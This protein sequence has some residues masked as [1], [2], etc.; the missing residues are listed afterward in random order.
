MELLP[1]EIRVLG[2]LLEKQHTTPDAYPLTLN[3]LRLAC[4]QST[5]RDPVVD[6]SEQ[7]VRDALQRLERQGLV[8]FASGAGSRAAKFRHLLVERISMDEAEQAVMCVLMLRGGQT[9]G[10]LKQRGERIHR[11]ADLA[12]VGTVLQRLM[13]RGLAARLPRQPGQKE[14]R[15]IHLLAA[16]QVAS[17]DMG[18]AQ[19]AT[20]GAAAGQPAGIGAAAGRPAVT[21]TSSDSEDD[22]EGWHG[23]ATAGLPGAAEESPGA[24]VGA[25][26]TVRA[27]A[28]PGAASAGAAP[29]QALSEQ[30]LELRRLSERV[31]RLERELASL[32]EDLG[33]ETEG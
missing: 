7:Q 6:Y 32:K 4:N 17:M 30:A 5:N 16:E 2:C 21:D 12:E 25:E 31:L 28:L 13:E 22:V 10:E 33:V 27:E 29:D 14:E 8:R 19:P 20:I 3:S 15:Y 11:F 23:D 24:P 26:E 18:S 1:I 9:P